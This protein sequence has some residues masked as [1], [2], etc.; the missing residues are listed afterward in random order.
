MSDKSTAPDPQPNPLE[1]GT[2]RY[3]W[4]WLL[5]KVKSK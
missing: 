1:Q 2:L 4:R 5:G 3:W